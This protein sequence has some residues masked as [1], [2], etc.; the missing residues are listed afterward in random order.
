[1]IA[2]ELINLLNCSKICAESHLH[3]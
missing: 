2:L 3:K 1:M